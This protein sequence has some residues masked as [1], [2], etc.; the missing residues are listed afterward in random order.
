MAWSRDN[1]AR[2]TFAVQDSGPGL[3]DNLMSV[4]A[5][6]RKPTVESPVVMGPDQAQLGVEPPNAEQNIPPSADLAGHS[7]RSRQGEGVGLQ[8]VKRL[9]ELLEASLAIETHPG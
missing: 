7:L 5:Q 6:Q 2:W 9:C 1:D 4:F 8:I 3:P